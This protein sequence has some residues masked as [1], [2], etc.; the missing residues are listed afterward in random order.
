MKTLTDFELLEK[1][2]GL[3][4]GMED[5]HEK[6][7]HT[8]FESLKREMEGIN[9]EL[10]LRRLHNLAQVDELNDLEPG[11]PQ[12]R[13]LNLRSNSSP[14]L[15]RAIIKAAKNGFT[16]GRGI[17]S[18]TGSGALQ[19]P[20]VKSTYFAESMQRHDFFKKTGI[21]VVNVPNYS[22]WPIFGEPA[23]VWQS[24]ENT[25]I[26]ESSMT[27][28]SKKIEMRT[29]AI[30][31]KLSKQISRDAGDLVEKM[32]NDALLQ[33][34]ANELGRVVLRGNGTTEPTGIDITSDVESYDVSGA[35]ITTWSPHLRILNQVHQN[36][37]IVDDC[38]WIAGS[39][40]MMQIESLD[41][42]TGQYL[43]KPPVLQNMPFV[44]SSHVSEAYTTNTRTKMYLGSFSNVI[45]GVSGPYI[46]P[47]RERYADTLTDA[48][49][50]YAGVDTL[51]KRPGE[52]GI[53]TNIGLA[54]LV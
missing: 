29:C 7:D 52:L 20:I 26:S 46:L 42:S 15:A 37:A 30:L 44:Y 54:W 32:I 18:T 47:L 28:T 10:Y 41:D 49:I 19:D 12:E 33:A 36:G 53:I 16:E 27:I 21:Q 22:Q 2:A 5:A 4:H 6:K 43:A 35:L 51:I 14:E 11:V 38:S 3:F 25:E 23:P 31:V 40:G 13:G 17:T 8:L 50:L 45:V 48:F 34:F 24:S 9:S 1:R 39:N